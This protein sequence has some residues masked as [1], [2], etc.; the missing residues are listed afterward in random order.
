MFRV[1]KLEDTKNEKVDIELFTMNQIGYENGKKVRDESFKTLSF[2]VYDDNY[3]FSFELKCRLEKLLEIP[4]N[5]TIDFSDYLFSGETF[6]SA[7]DSNVTEPVTN[8]KITRY[9]KNEFIILI[10]FYTDY[11]VDD[12]ND[13]SGVIEFTFDLDD[14]LD[15][16]KKD[17]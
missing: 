6:F 16:E 15:K 2:C 1:S 4:M 13:Y 9:M 3:S 5:K 11:Y 10:S 12:D 8:I 7:G 14:Y 17:V